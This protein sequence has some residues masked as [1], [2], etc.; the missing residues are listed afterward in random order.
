MKASLILKRTGLMWGL[1]L[2]L[3]LALPPAAHAQYRTANNAD[4]TLTITRYT[5]PG[6]TVA[7]P[8]RLNGRRVTRIGRRAFKGSFNLTRVTIPN[9]VTRINDHAFMSCFS[10]SSVSIPSSVT[11]IGESAFFASG[12]RSVTIP[13][14]VTHLGDQAFHNC[15]K[16]ADVRLGR[17]ITN[18][19]FWTFSRCQR[20]VQVE[21][22]N[23]VRGI[24][25]WAFNSCTRLQ[26]VLV[27]AGVEE[28]WEDAFKDC[29]R[30]T[31][32]NFQG[33]RPALLMGNLFSNSTRAVSYYLPWRT[34]WGATYSG[35]PAR[36]GD[37]YEPDNSRAAAKTIAN[38]QTQ[39]R[40]IHRAG[41]ADWAKFTIGAGGARNLR[42]D[43]A[44]AGG[45]LEMWLYKGN[46]QLVAYDD[47]SGPGRYPRLA[48]ATLNRGTYFIKL[49]EKGHDG[50]LPFFSLAAR[51]TAR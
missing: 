42:I 31:A 3:V 10:L 45:D 40:S 38:G 12:L 11:R 50:T 28:I 39:F 36:P 26:S 1:G 41:N 35:R 29:P 23:R 20:L 32:V 33:N 43:T 15:G 16:L 51:W 37:A 49:Q 5:G 46:G 48:V 34:G 24:Q 13:D 22:P 44:G 14:S 19:G 6:G 25:S 18:I 4:G 47:D 7:I 21:I 2:A 30:L 9:T 8:G 17:G 27:G